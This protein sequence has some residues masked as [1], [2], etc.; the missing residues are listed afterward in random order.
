MANAHFNP[1]LAP[2]VPRKTND[3]LNSPFPLLA[4]LAPKVA[5]RANVLPRQVVE[6]R[7]EVADATEVMDTT[8]TT[9]VN[10]RFPSVT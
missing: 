1:L 5:R 2:L 7:E 10:K 9:V 4:P 3:L 6:D 8:V